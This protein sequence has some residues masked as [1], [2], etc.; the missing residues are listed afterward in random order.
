V[1]RLVSPDY[2]QISTDVQ[3]MLSSVLANQ[4]APAQALSQTAA[5][6]AS[7]SK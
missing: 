3:N 7:L 5:E 4:T 1:P 2:L 6:L